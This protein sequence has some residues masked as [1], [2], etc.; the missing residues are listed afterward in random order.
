MTK[1]FYMH[2]D[3]MDVCME[4]VRIPYR[5]NKRYRLKIRWW[6]LGYTGNPW[7]LDPML[8]SLTIFKTDAHWIYINN[9]MNKKRL[10]PGLP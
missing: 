8:F 7:L 3:A 6:N 2:K 4:V 5:D 9:L 1:G 10:K